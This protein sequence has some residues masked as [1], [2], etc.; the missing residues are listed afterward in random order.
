[1]SCTP[2]PRAL[3]CMPRT[4]AMKFPLL[5]VPPRTRVRRVPAA[6]RR[7]FVHFLARQEAP[8]LIALHNEKS[9]SK[10]LVGVRMY[11]D[12]RN[13]EEVVIVMVDRDRRPVS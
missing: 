3:Y 5:A 8:P 11:C 6:L 9:F 4:G 7:H 1:M 13:W 10:F 12:L 2:A